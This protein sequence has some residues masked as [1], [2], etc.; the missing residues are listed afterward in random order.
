[1]ADRIV[2]DFNDWLRLG[3]EAGWVSPDY[4]ITH[5]GTPLTVDEEERADTDEYGLDDACLHGLRLIPPGEQLA[6]FYARWGDNPLS[7]LEPL[8]PEVAAGVEMF[9]AE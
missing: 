3:V 7:H 9:K 2:L 5:D 8:S 4:C 1:M 6:P